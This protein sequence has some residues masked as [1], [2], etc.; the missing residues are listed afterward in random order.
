M[1]HHGLYRLLLIPF[2]IK[3]TPG[4]FKR[5]ID[6]LLPTVKWHNYIVYLYDSIVFIK[7]LEDL[8]CPVA[9]EILP[10]KDA[11]VTLNL[12][13]DFIHHRGRFTYPRH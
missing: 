7:T 6:V 9:S 12:K 1:L 8:I 11:V 5:V 3:I 13:S 10:V 2:C 4:S